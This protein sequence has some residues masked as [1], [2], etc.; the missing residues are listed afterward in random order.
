MPRECYASLS[1]LP[2]PLFIAIS[3]LSA[4]CFA[5]EQSCTDWPRNQEITNLDLFERA[6]AE[7]PGLCAMLPHELPESIAMLYGSKQAAQYILQLRLLN[8]RKWYRGEVKSKRNVSFVKFKSDL[9][10][11]EDAYLDSQLVELR[12]L[13]V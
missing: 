3:R 6:L 8:W 13:A 10:L 11:K 12:K 5:Y 7:I 9:N 1:W 4:A 2:P